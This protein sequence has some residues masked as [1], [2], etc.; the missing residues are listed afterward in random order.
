MD[1][2]LLRTLR[3]ADDPVHWECPPDFP[4]KSALAQVAELQ[5]RLEEVVGQALVLD[6]NVQDASHFTELSWQTVPRPVPGIGKR[7]ILTYIA[8]RFSAFGRLA[9]LW[10]NVPEAPLDAELCGRIA[11]VLV[12]AGYVVV[13]ADALDEPYDGTNQFASQIR[14][15][16]LRYFD[17]C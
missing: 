10:G 16:W 15:W 2:A 1:V 9:T 3:E 6:T 8:I 4:W 7:V 12:N 13:P 5:P 14:T 11:R 17:Y